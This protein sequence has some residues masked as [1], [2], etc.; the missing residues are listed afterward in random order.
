MATST[1]IWGDQLT[2]DESAQLERWSG[3]IP[4][5]RPDVLV[6]R[7]GILGVA[8]AAAVRRAGV[9]SVLLIEAGRLGSRASG[10]A[11][12]AAAAAP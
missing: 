9:G 6:V 2:A 5:A 8:T 11:A 12:G 4:Q 3:T 1:A 10:G 7:G